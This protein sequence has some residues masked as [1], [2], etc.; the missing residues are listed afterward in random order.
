VWL[1]PEYRHHFDADSSWDTRNGCIAVSN[2]LRP[3]SR[4]K[5]D[6]SEC[7]G[8]LAVRSGEERQGNLNTSKGYKRLFTN[9][10]EGVFTL[11][12]DM[13]LSGEMI[14]DGELVI[15]EKDFLFED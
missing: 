15:D 14:G 2:S 7:P 12:L 4:L 5:F 9:H 8:R 11:H 1:P 10:N 13:G 6:C 3:I